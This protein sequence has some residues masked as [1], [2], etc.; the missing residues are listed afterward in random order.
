MEST[1]IKT[2]C[3]FILSAALLGSCAGAA[4]AAPD[5]DQDEK[6]VVAAGAND[7]EVS[8]SLSC[9][10]ESKGSRTLEV[11][12]PNAD[13]KLKY[14]M[15]FSANRNMAC[16]KVLDVSAFSGSRIFQVGSNNKR[17][18][19]Q[20]R[21]GSWVNGKIT[22]GKWGSKETGVAIAPPKIVALTSPA[23]KT[24]RVNIAKTKGSRTDDA[25]YEILV[26]GGSWSAGGIRQVSGKSGQKTFAVGLSKHPYKVK[27]RAWRKVGGL[28][29]CSSYGPVKSVV[30]R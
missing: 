28:Y 12:I 29:Y 10:V 3:S 5:T 30:S 9:F 22:W 11:T 14:Q 7:S 21:E 27:A 23:S 26:T 16:S 8:E 13:T 19:V 25:A 18:F 1:T 17:Y 4:Y 6:V 2:A 24:L 20:C 15:R